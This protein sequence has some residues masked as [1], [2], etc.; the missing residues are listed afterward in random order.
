[1]PLTI[2]GGWGYLRLIVVDERRVEAEAE[3]GE[4]TRGISRESLMA[5]AL[6][7]VTIVGFVGSCT[8]SISVDGTAA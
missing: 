3:D 4:V 1:M 6:V 7:P 8:C 2:L 5:V